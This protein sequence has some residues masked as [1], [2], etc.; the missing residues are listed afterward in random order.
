MNCR[1]CN[2]KLKKFMTF[3]KMPIA[4]AF[5]KNLK[6]R[7]YFFELAPSYCPKC[8]LFQLIKQPNPKKLFHKNY[9][10]FAGTSLKMQNHFKNL[11][12][13]LI[14]NFKLKKD[15]LTVEIGNNDGGVVHYLSKRNFRNLGVD[16]STNVAKSAK[17]KGVNI[18]NNFFNFQTAKL[19]KKKYG[20]VKVFVAQNTLAHIPNIDSVFKGVE[21]ILSK[22]GIMVTEDPYLPEMLRKCS[23]DQ[24]YDE[25]VFIF[26]LT[27]IKNICEKHGLQVFD[28]EKLDTAGGSLRYFICRN[29]SRKIK[30]KVLSQ[31]KF[32]KKL[33]LLNPKTYKKF[34][35]S[36][37]K[38]KKSL[39]NILRKL[40]KDNKTIVGYGAT[41]KSTTIF[42]YCG[43]NSNLIDYITDTTPTK[44]DKFTPGTHIPVKS[45]E[46][47]KKNY[48][49][50][51]LLLAW[52]HK[53]EIFKKEKYRYS[54]RGN[55]IIH[56]PKL[57]IIKK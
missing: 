15:D 26:S 30:Q 36:C 47:F 39:L 24:I 33:N 37:E 11:A 32:E 41:S 19:I 20:P 52:N 48:P 8:S 38:S 18:F 6:Q 31:F 1:N 42:N 16:P 23:Y 25:H 45:H 40:K 44:I 13:K 14:T 22:N 9:A 29:G 35:N 53:N 50:Y 43:I 5:V 17:R 21:T 46:H 2:K 4:N 55:W 34:K 7:E 51:A 57:R 54:T 12:T 49:D 27:A 3:G 56:L 10:F 28:I